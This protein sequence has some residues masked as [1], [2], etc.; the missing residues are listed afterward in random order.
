LEAISVIEEIVAVSR[1]VGDE[2]WPGYRPHESAFLIFRPGSRSFLV[3][4]RRIAP[5]LEELGIPGV[6]SRVYVVPA[7]E[8]NLGSGLPFVKGFNIRGERAMVVRHTDGTP[9]LLF[10]RLAVHELF[11]DY[12]E[13]A[14]VGLRALPVCRYPYDDIPRVLLARVEDQALSEVLTS[15]AE[16][17]ATPREIRDALVVYLDWR[18]RRYDRSDLDEMAHIETYEE[19]LEGTARYIDL[20]YSVVAGYQ[21][22]QEAFRD[23]AGDLRRFNPAALQK[24]KYYQTGLALALVLDRLSLDG[25]KTE[26]EKGDCLYA[27]AL[28]EMV[29]HLSPP[30]PGAPAEVP[31]RYTAGWPEVRQS[32]E[33]YIKREVDLL[34]RWAKE[35]RYSVQLVF[36]TRGKGYYSSR[37]ITLVTK[38]CKR[39][40]S[41]LISFSDAEYHF[42]VRNRGMLMN[43][44]ETGF[45]LV[46]YHDLDKGTVELDGQPVS[47]QDGTL[48]FSRHIQ[49]SLPDFRWNHSCSGSVSIRGNTVQIVLQ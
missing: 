35:G 17:K 36:P 40:V 34:E 46:F 28:R 23:L 4:P 9:R 31:D 14:F 18:S 5:G 48:A 16:S 19:R 39:F 33:A 26:C 12:Q 13:R 21:T 44:Q 45:N 43:Y 15:I 11:H 25:W 41:R 6:A 10:F 38:D 7:E 47:I 3:T 2:I 24:W 27:F 20:M 30:I 22:I 8:L 49:V 1:Q 29:Q 37:G 32:L 42:E